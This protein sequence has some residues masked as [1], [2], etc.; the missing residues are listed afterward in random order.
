MRHLGQH[1][2]SLPNLVSCRVWSKHTPVYRY[3]FNLTS[4]DLSWCIL[5]CSV[6][7]LVKCSWKLRSTRLLIHW[8]LM[9]PN[10]NHYVI[11]MWPWM[12]VHSIEPRTC[13]SACYD[14]SLSWRVCLTV[15]LPPGHRCGIDRCPGEGVGG[16]RCGTRAR[17]VPGSES[18]SKPTHR[19]LYPNLKFALISY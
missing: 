10:P 11:F 3:L 19:C 6:W 18:P 5:N 7:P 1:L 2:P 17:W 8:L 16:S 14:Q 9:D 13:T 15:T 12:C 4:L